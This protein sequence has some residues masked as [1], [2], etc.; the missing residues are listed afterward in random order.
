MKKPLSKTLLIGSLII[1]LALITLSGLFAFGLYSRKVTGY[2]RDSIEQEISY[3]VKNI[4][5]FL[6]YAGND[7]LFLSKLFSLNDLINAQ[8]KDLRDQAKLD[9]QQD[10][11]G[12][13]T[14][15]KVYYQ[16]RYNDENGQEIVRV[17]S[18]GKNSKIIPENELQDK[19]K[20]FYFYDTMVLQEG[21]V[22]ISSLDLNVEQG[23]LENRG[24]EDEPAYMP[25]IRYATPVFNKAGES[26]GIVITNIYAEYFLKEIQEN[27]RTKGEIMLV[28]AKGFYLS[29]SHSGK[30][31]EFMFGKKSSFYDDY[32]EVAR[33]LLANAGQ[34][35]LE[36]KDLIIYFR[37]IYP[38]FKN[39]GIEGVE[40]ATFQGVPKENHFWVLIIVYPK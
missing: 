39:L 27:R 38:A 10:F 18:D 29:H 4:D 24:T 34:T 15:K 22:F 8:R 14:E 25:V 9:L 28:N 23:R 11:L 33:D 1:F 13:S 26:K 31:F 12:F 16:I 17:D 30:E 19:K 21:E 40:K 3:K 35:F 7:A 20:R 32:P 5:R 37:Y 2:P 6:M 36:T